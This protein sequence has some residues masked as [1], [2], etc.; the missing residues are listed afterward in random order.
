[1]LDD[2]LGDLLGDLAVLINGD[3]R[4]R[5]S[6]I[7]RGAGPAKKPRLFGSRGF[8]AGTEGL[9]SGTVQAATKGL[10]CSAPAFGLRP[11]I[12]AGISHLS[13]QIGCC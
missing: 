1:M 5:Q 4:S 2:M 6:M 11:D 12:G 10:T 8:A 13:S 9:H 7:N 3:L